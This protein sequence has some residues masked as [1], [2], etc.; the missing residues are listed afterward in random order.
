MYTIV[1]NGIKLVPKERRARGLTERKWKSSPSPSH[2][3]CGFF[4]R[5]IFVVVET[6]T[7]HFVWK[8]IS[9][10]QYVSI[11]LMPVAAA[12]LYNAL[13]QRLREYSLWHKRLGHKC[14]FSLEFNSGR[15]T[16][17]SEHVKYRRISTRFYA[18]IRLI[19]NGASM[20]TAQ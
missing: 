19:M 8:W 11:V 2:R 15:S 18:T 10:E 17:V 12:N 5:R 16:T 3:R 14:N 1:Y 4:H 9:S 13:G 20:Q 7:R 6:L